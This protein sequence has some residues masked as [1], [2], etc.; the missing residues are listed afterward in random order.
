MREQQAHETRLLYESLVDMVSVVTY[1]STPDRKHFLSLSK[2]AEELTGITREE[3]LVNPSKWSDSIHYDDRRQVVNA[4]ASQPIDLVIEYRFVRANGQE[5][6]IRDCSRLVYQEGRPSFVQGIL[7]QADAGCAPT[8]SPI[9]SEMTLA[10]GV[11]S[12]TGLP[13]RTSLRRIIRD[14]TLHYDS[15]HPLAAMLWVGVDR[16]KRINEFHGH[17]VGDCV[18]LEI[19]KRIQEHIGT[20]SLLARV[21]GDE[22]AAVICGKT[23]SDI[24]SIAHRIRSYLKQPVNTGEDEIHLTASTGIYF[25]SLLDNDSEQS[26]RCSSMAFH[27]ARTAGR[28]AVKIYNPGMGAEKHRKGKIEA[29]LR[30]ALKTGGMEVFYQPKIEAR[31][32]NITGFEALVRCYSEDRHIIMPS[33]FIPIAEEIGLISQIGEW[34]LYEGCRQA[35]QWEALNPNLTIAINVSGKQL[36]AGDL[37]SLVKDAL[38]SSGLSPKKLEIELTESVLIE[39]M[40][41]ATRALVAISNMGVRVS[42]DD[43]GTGY[44]SL[45]YLNRFQIHTVKID[46]SFIND[47]VG[48]QAKIQMVEA[49]I[50]IAH[51][52]KMKVIAEGIEAI[53]QAQLLRELECDELQGYYFGKPANSLYTTALIVNNGHSSRHALGGG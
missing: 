18:L 17:I 23:D 39:H 5:I 42:I 24:L 12:L 2:Q 48:D 6:R 19:K 10:Q 28:D 25:F 14:R 30:N 8:L 47:V 20:G 15:N 52:L 38:D 44:S 43:F 13:D 41:E 36:K 22:F 45:A 29:T 33:E 26:I 1:V 50:S 9:Q 40:E 11:D 46:K 35:K 27:E 7:S 32:F 49:I 21:G 4:H 16:F 37:D 3:L 34:V 31:S 53:E 51:K